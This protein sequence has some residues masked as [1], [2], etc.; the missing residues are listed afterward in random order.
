MKPKAIGIIILICALGAL[1]IK[2]SQ[3]QKESESGLGKDQRTTGSMDD[4]N[5]TPR[6]SQRTSKSSNISSG[7][8]R[9]LFDELAR[10]GTSGERIEEIVNIL[11]TRPF[12]EVGVLAVQTFC[13]IKHRQNYGLVD[14]KCWLRPD[15]PQHEKVRWAAN[16]IWRNVAYTKEKLPISKSLTTLCLEQRPEQ[17]K[18]FYILALRGHYQNNEKILVEQIAQDSNQPPK[19]SAKAA[20]IL[21][22]R[23]NSPDQYYSLLLSTCDRIPNLSERSYEFRT[24]TYAVFDELSD[25][26]KVKHLNYGFNLLKR[27]I[28]APNSSGY[29][30]ADTLAWHLKKTKELRIEQ[31]QPK[32]KGSYEQREQFFK[33]TAIITLKWWEK[34]KERINSPTE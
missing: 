24:S 13:S 27:Q 1:F 15:C 11:S 33:D 3:D 12:E 28:E 23:E 2:H 4:S 29:H 31:N 14:G 22:K 7:S 16:A 30:L 20:S 18:M 26:N 19:I 10:S 8:A 9:M 21:L 5:G 6:S 32:Y 25:H 34:N 17:E